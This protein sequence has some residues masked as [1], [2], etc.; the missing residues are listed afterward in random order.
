MLAIG[1]LAGSL[2]A[3]SSGPKGPGYKDVPDY[4]I[5]TVTSEDE[6]TSLIVVPVGRLAFEE[7]IERSPS[8]SSVTQI[9]DLKGDRIPGKFALSPDGQTIVFPMLE[10][11]PRSKWNLWRS[12]S[13]GSGGISRVTAGNY[14]DTTPAFSADGKR[15]YFSSNRNS[16]RPRVWSVQ[17]DGVG[18]I[19]MLTQGDA[20][21]QSPSQN[22]KS[23]R[24][25]YQ[26]MPRFSTNW[27]VWAISPDGGLPTQMTEGAEPRVSPDGSTILFSVPDSESELLKLW[28][29]GAQGTNPTQ[30]TDGEDSQEINASWSPDGNRIVFASDQAKDS[31]GK[32]NYDIWM[33]NR[34]GTGLTQLTTNGSTDWAP[35]FGPNGKFVYFLS[36]R[37]FN[38]EIWRMSIQ[39]AAG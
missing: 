19:S 3:C 30:L 11:Q 39:P 6:G 20:F 4:Q 10:F 31:N 35:V 14:F 23:E 24:I 38:W 22:S 13:D 5:K 15:I 17:A 8:V 18:G 2:G 28:V 1:L 29:M 34:D 27:Q 12:S 7:T 21:D 33:M 26:S 25:F 36:N 9:T 32:Q 37:G 16:L